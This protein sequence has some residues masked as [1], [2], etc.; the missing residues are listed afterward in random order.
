MD[1]YSIVHIWWEADRLLDL[2]AVKVNRFSGASASQ[3]LLQL[4][5]DQRQTGQTHYYAALTAPETTT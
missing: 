4:S 5:F 2:G 1:V 3:A